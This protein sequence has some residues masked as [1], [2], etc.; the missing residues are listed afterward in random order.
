MRFAFL[1]GASLERTEPASATNREAQR[2]VNEDCSARRQT[3]TQRVRASPQ[4]GMDV[5]FGTIIELKSTMALVQY[6]AFG[7]QMKGLDQEWVQ[8]SSLSAGSNCPN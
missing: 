2:R 4:I 1:S 8:L 7:R 3:Y 5:A 6:N